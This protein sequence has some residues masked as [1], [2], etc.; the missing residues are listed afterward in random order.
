MVATDS[1]RLSVK[2]TA[3]EPPLQGALEAN[4]PARALQELVRIA[5]QTPTPSRSSVSRGA[6]PGRLRARR[7]RALLA[8]DRRPVPQLPPAAAG[9]RRARAAPGDRRA[10]PRSCGASACS[11]RRTRR[12]GSASARATL[13]VSAQTPDVGEASEAIPVPFHGEPFEIGFNPEF[14]RDGL[15]SVEAEELVLKLISPLRPGLIESPDSGRL[16]L[17]DHAHPPE[18]VSA[19]RRVRAS[20]WS[21]ATSAA[22]RAPRRALGDGPDA[23]STGPTAP[24]SR[25]L[26]EAIYFGCTGRSPRTRNERELVRFGA[27]AARVDGAA[28]RRRA[29]RTSSRSASG[30]PPASAQPVKRMS[31]DG[32]AVER[33]LDVAFRPL[34]S[35]FLPD[36]LEL[37]KGPAGAA[38][39]PPRPARRGAL[40]GSRAATRREY[41]RALAQRNALL[42]RIRAGR[43]SRATLRG[44][45]PRARARRRCALRDAPR[46][47]RWSCSREPFAERAAQLGCAGEVDARVPP[48]LARATTRTRSSREL[49]RAARARPRSAASPATGP[50]ATSSRS[51][52]TAASCASYGSQGEQRLALLA[53]LLA[54][55]GVLARERGRT[56]L[57]LLDDVMS[58]LDA[59]APRAARRASS[60]AGGQSVIATTDLAHVPGA[61]DAAVARLRDLAGARSC[62]RRSPRE[63]RRRRARS[64]SALD[65]L[66]GG[67]RAGDARS[68]ASR[69]LG[70]RGG[71]RD[72]RRRA[73]RRRARR[74][75]HGDLR[76]G[77]LGAGARADGGRLIER[78]NAELGARDD[79]RAAL[80]ERLRPRPERDRRARRDAR[81]SRV[82]TAIADPCRHLPCILQAFRALRRA[83]PSA[84]RVLSFRYIS[85]RPG[86]GLRAPESG[87]FSRHRR[88]IGI[89]QRTARGGRRQRR[90]RTTRRQAASASYDAQDITVLEGLEAV[91]KRPGMYIGSTGVHG[92]APPRLRG[93]RQLRRR[94]ARRLLHARCRSRS[95]P[96]TPSR[97]STT[98]AA[99]PSR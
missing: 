31:A 93:R 50:T 12:C 78:L 73:A 65:R 55:R 34:V 4:V 83:G 69:R 1:Y 76:G 25:N 23:S 97:S 94:G 58:E 16:R 48:A 13:T 91:R 21:C 39:R 87:A 40:A 5:Q 59:R 44:V 68:R 99:S 28:A 90:R 47:R 8:P 80:P 86:R 15:E 67:A 54:E 89:T 45:G 96:T 27:Q 61:A 20:A 10:R 79:P 18:R 11:P 26:L 30:P 53:L 82:C 7:R 52:A 85:T 95:T 64:R 33:L 75:A 51:C 35:V 9:V 56:P 71:R 77:G 17:P 63:Q 2:Q 43:A 14:L 42:A 62:R 36:R 19:W 88:A 49:A 32:A 22:T 72:R 29:S 98:A 6:E 84:P 70:A 92:P 24:A 60:R 66:V 37:V 46:A 74:G 81:P 41:S 3:L 38:P 57:M